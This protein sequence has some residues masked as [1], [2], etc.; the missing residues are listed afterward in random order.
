M[1]LFSK[2]ECF[3]VRFSKVV[4]RL[5][6]RFFQS[7]K[8]EKN[9]LAFGLIIE[10]RNLETA[11]HSERVVQYATALGET[12][13][14]KDTQ[15]EVLCQGAYLHD[16]GKLA[17]PDAILLKPSELTPEEWVIM[18]THVERGFSLAL[19]IPGLHKGVLNVIKYHHERWDGCG[20]PEGLKE[21]S[22]PLEARI[23]AVCDVYDALI[24]ER[25]YKPAWSQVQ[26][27]TQLRLEAGKHFDPNVVEAFIESL[28]VS[29]NKTKPSESKFT[30]PVRE[31]QALFI[32]RSKALFS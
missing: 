5:F 24:S 12:I 27:I 10:A 6:Y 14:L 3:M 9:F 1:K 19:N 22:I 16:L 21:D 26:A 25:P 30:V 32:N 13:G 7:K 29:N 4:R 11:E 8:L 2:L 17:I 20:Y 23:F 28:T 15:L 18:K 31:S